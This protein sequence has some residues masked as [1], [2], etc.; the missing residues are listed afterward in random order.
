MMNTTHIF[1]GGTGEYNA[2]VIKRKSGKGEELFLRKLE[3][4][5]LSAFPLVEAIR[6]NKAAMVGE[7]I[8]EHWAFGKRFGAGVDNR[9]AR[10]GVFEAPDTLLDS[11]GSLLVDDGDLLCGGN[12]VAPVEEW[13]KFD[14][15][16]GFKFFLPAFG[17]CKASAHGGSIEPRTG[18]N[19]RESKLDCV[20][21]IGFA[22]I[23]VNSRLLFG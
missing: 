5:G 3:I 17:L 14:F 20:L 1:I 7:Q 21:D 12:V 13:R 10:A 4:V 9:C 22:C 15:S 2:S 11:R 8:L 23:D 18:T 6:G 19:Q 16:K